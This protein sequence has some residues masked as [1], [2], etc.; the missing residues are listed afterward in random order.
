M[1][2]TIIKLKLVMKL[3]SEKEVCDEM[4]QLI[5][6]DIHT[7]GV[8]AKRKHLLI[9]KVLSNLNRKSDQLEKKHL[10]LHN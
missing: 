3:Q 8:D 2:N 10:F 6:P 4:N 9:L 5:H 1:K 7:L